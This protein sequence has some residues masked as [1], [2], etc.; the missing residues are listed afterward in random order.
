MRGLR[1]R[2]VMLILLKTLACVILRFLPI[3]FLRIFFL[4]HEKLQMT[5]R[6]SQHACSRENF[7]GWHW[8]DSLSRDSK[9]LQWH[10][11]KTDQ[12]S[13]LCQIFLSTVFN[14]CQLNMR[15]TKLLCHS[16]RSNF[17]KQ[18]NHSLISTKH[19]AF[20]FYNGHCLIRS[21]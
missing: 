8:H 7:L 18:Q 5:F 4:Q 6:R 17:D 12:H 2:T 10:D 21:H 20:H 9:T 3:W 1:I 19:H 16:A 11:M 15:S 14:V 13:N